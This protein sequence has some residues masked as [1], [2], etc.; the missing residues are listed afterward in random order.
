[1]IVAVAALLA[2]MSQA[3][4]ISW[5]NVG[6]T[7]GLYALDGT[8]K[9]TAA[10]ATAWGLTVTLMYADGTSTGA[11]ATAIN[12]MTAGQLTGSGLNWTY[13]YSDTET[14][15]GYAKS[16]TQFYIHAIMKVD[17]KDYEMDIGKDS[18]FTIAATDNTG[19]DTFTWASGTYGGLAGTATAGSKG[20]WSAVPEP[21]SG[22]L[23]LLGM[24]GLALRRRC[25]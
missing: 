2:G 11:S 17:G 22:L 21:T 13:T 16:G 24:A 5:G 6:S 4:S 1:M 23:M 3:A 8:S 12:S 18:P 25:A 20:A 15:V 19:K 9:I 14:G 7:S 10:N